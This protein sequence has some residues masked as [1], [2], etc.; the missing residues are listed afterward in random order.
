MDCPTC[1]DSFD[2]RQGTRIHHSHAHGEKLPN[3]T[4]NGCGTDFYDP[5]S[6]LEYCGDCDP[7][8]GENNGNWR[9]ARETGACRCCGAEFRYYPSDK[10]G[11][12][13]SGCMEDATGL[14]P[15]NPATKSRVSV[16][17]TQCDA[18]IEARPA[19]VENRKRGVFCNLDCYGSWLSENVVSEDHHQWEGGELDYGEKWWRVRREALDR[20]D[21]SCQNCGETAEEIGRNPDVHHI[22]RVR[23][24]D[25]PQEAHALENVVTLCRSCHRN[26]EA[27]NVSVPATSAEK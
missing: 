19:R 4:C 8:A 12:Y 18:D 2:S 6:R 5:K 14:L 22:K 25:C 26:V 3:R 16:S 27:G 17:C 21:Y 7:N 9:D 11:T 24:F 20:D 10:D 23:N 13:C 1:E 15:E